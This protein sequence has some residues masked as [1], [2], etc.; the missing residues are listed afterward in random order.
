MR[1]AVLT[2][3]GAF[4]LPEEA[5]MELLKHSDTLAERGVTVDRPKSL[6][7]DALNRGAPGGYSRERWASLGHG[8]AHIREPNSPQ[9]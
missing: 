5:A 6:S 4:D 3:G 9:C 8:H 7:L 1:F 2:T